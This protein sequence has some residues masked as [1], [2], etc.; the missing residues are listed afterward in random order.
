MFEL[1][2]CDVDSR[3]P[4]S[5]DGMPGGLTSACA[6]SAALYRRIGYAAP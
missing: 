2:P 6:R 4:R 3:P 5:I 1:L